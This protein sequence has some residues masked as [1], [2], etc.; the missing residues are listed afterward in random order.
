[1]IISKMHLG[2]S[3]NASDIFTSWPSIQYFPGKSFFSVNNFYQLFQVEKLFESFWRTTGME[4][5]GLSTK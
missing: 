5:L 1:M 2:V 3:S 4:K